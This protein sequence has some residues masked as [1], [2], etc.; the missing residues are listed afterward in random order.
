M[1]MKKVRISVNGLVEFY[2]QQPELSNWSPIFEG[3]DSIADTLL[4]LQELQK[5]GIE[6]I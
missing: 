4:Y 2:Q 3:I 5:E 6:Y 1:E